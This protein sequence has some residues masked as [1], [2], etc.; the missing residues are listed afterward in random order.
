MS[1]QTDKIVYDKGEPFEGIGKS[2]KPVEKVVVV[3]TKPM[4][5]VR[6]GGLRAST[7]NDSIKA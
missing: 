6:Q 2:S 7:V 5:L 4:K 1:K 3:K